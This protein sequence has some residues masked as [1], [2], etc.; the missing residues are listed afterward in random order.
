MESNQHCEDQSLESEG[1]TV[2]PDEGPRMLK[3]MDGKPILILRNHGLL[4]WGETLPQA[5]AHLWTVQRACE[6]RGCRHEHG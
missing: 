4:A 1:I 5:L 6:N 2:N 3:A